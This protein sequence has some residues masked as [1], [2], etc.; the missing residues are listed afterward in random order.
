MTSE[1]PFIGFKELI[2]TPLSTS[3]IRSFSIIKRFIIEEQP[4]P[5]QPFTLLLQKLTGKVITNDEATTCWKQIIKHKVF[6]QQKLGRTV[7]IQTAAIDYFEHQ[8]PVAKLFN[9]SPDQTYKQI[10]SKGKK[11]ESV[12]AQSYHHKKLKEEMLRA[13]RYKHALSVIILVIDNFS[14]IN[15]SLSYNEGNQVQATIVNIIKKTIRNV[16]NLDRLSE[17]R[18]F[19][20]LPNTNN[21]EAR[22]LAERIRININNRTTRLSMLPKGITAT[23]S[24][25][26]CSHSDTS[27]EFIRRIERVLEDGKRQNGNTVFAIS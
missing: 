2:Q 12:Y 19:L 5:S 4:D 7:G 14:K 16:D 9:L 26:Q 1:L 10:S 3:D 8:S 17:D 15:E 22:A 24:M 23:L 13:K 25:G 20:I 21:R 27:I 18:F 11:V 6:L